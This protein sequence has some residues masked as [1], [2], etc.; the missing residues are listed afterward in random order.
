M[1][2]VK[3]GLFREIRLACG[4][5]QRTIATALGVWQ[6]SVHR[7]ETG[8]TQPTGA[9]GKRYLRVMEGLARHLEVRP[10]KETR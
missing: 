3:R 10:D 1:P 5:R 7:W 2:T 6:S 9:T 4:I 8:A